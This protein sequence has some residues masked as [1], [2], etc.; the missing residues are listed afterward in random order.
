MVHIVGFTGLGF[1]EVLRLGGMQASGF[2]VLQGFQGIDG[3]S[4]I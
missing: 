4:G 2:W 3:L 1:I